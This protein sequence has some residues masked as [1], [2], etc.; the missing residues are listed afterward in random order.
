MEFVSDTKIQQTFVIM[1][2]TSRTCKISLY[3]YISRNIT[4]KIENATFR[5]LFL[6]MSVWFSLCVSVCLSL[7]ISLPSL[8]L[9]F[10]LI[11]IR[12]IF[13]H[14]PNVAGFYYDRHAYKYICIQNDTIDAYISPTKS[15]WLSSLK[16]HFL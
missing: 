4:L 6:S 2:C 8:C 16:I 1:Y 15:L 5:C 12:F 11:C 14:R 9:S 13:M 3:L 10:H 7:S